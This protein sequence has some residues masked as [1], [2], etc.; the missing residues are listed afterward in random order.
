MYFRDVRDKES[1]SSADGKVMQLTPYAHSDV[2]KAIGVPGTPR[3]YLGM[4]KWPGKVKGIKGLDS[5]GT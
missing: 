3:Q 1:Y 4:R 2:V 5:F